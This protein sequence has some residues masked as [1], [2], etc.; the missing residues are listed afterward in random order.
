MCVCIGTLLTSQK[1]PFLNFCAM[2]QRWGTHWPV[3]LTLASSCLTFRHR[4]QLLGHI[5]GVLWIPPLHPQL[6]QSADLKDHKYKPQTIPC[7]LAKTATSRKSVEGEMQSWRYWESLRHT[8]SLSS[9][10]AW[11]LHDIL[12]SHTYWWKIEKNVHAASDAITYSRGMVSQPLLYLQI[13]NL[14]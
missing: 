13:P 2:Q 5:L 3:A 7:S 11:R 9:R 6:L 10:N 4:K 8:Q 14:P 12:R 1:W